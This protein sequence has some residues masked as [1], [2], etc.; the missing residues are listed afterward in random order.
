M[1]MNTKRTAQLLLLFIITSVASSQELY[2]EIGKTSSSFDY[3]NSQGYKLDNLQA[4]THNFMTLGYRFSIPIE[5]LKGSFGVGYMS[6]GSTGSDNTITGVMEWNANYVELN[7][8]LDYS[9][10]N[11][12][13]TSF[14]IKGMFST[15]FLIQGTQ[16]LNSEIIN[17]KNVDDFNEVMISFKSGAGFLHSVSKELS[18]YVQYFFGKS[19]NQSDNLDYESLRIKSHNLSFGVLI[20]VLN[21]R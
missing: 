16:S 8:S 5:K 17:L 11:I 18:F 15:G 2:L 10:F 12:K 13:K 20:N 7:T 4:T 19:L 9:L 3:K 14:Y 1:K 21:N 6:Y